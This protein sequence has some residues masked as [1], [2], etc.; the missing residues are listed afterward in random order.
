MKQLLY[1]KIHFLNQEADEDVAA[2]MVSQFRS[3]AGHH[4]QSKT[5]PV[6]FQDRMVKIQCENAH[7][8][9]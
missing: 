4:H 8:E 9:K 6:K 2:T 1:N 3:K 7:R 5:F